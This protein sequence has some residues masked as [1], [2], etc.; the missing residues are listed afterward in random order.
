MN[1]PP[2]HPS[3]RGLPLA[4]ALSAA[5]ALSGP[6]LAQATPAA[7]PATTP[8][9]TQ[10]PAP[11]PIAAQNYTLEQA[12]AQLAGAPSVTRAALSVQVAQQNLEAARSALGLTVSVNGNASYVGSGAGTASDGAAT[13]T[14]A[15]LGGNAG[16]SVSLGLLPW[17]NNQS[18][19]RAS[20]RSLALARA[21][22]QEAQR[23]ARLNVTQAYFDAVLATQDLQMGAQTVALRTRQLQVAQAQDA[24]GNAAPEAVLSAQAALQAAQSA[25]AQA[26][27]TLDTA[28]RTLESALGV[29]LGRVTFSPPAQATL[30][31]P[32]V[33][34]LVARARTGRADVISAQNT[35]AA[36]QDTLDTAVRDATLP[37]LTA[38]VGYGG[39][40]AGTLST[41][42]NLKQGTLSSAYSVPVGSS[43]GSAS[44]RLTASLSGSY[45]VYSPAQRAS[46][47]ADQASVTQAALSLTVAQQNVELDVR[48]RFITAQQALTAVQ[49][50]QTQVQV[51]QQQLATAQARVQAGTA[52]PD[53]VQ[54]AELTLAQAQRD[55]LSARLS[56]QTTLI[57]LDNAAGGPQ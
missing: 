47:S 34:A 6:A 30:T 49:T 11:Q 29:S 10:A 19:L 33:A 43:S 53:D 27:G 41:S 12:Y 51:A 20:E 46:L 36:A 25:A 35:L 17:S 57:Q 4:L 22:L 42:L 14:A 40:S 9:T 54:S 52:T 37:D 38:S 7:P 45:V 1:L 18:S 32:D 48:S 5:L 16:V 8:T 56:A 15:S 28:Q 21:T 44:G 2:A 26:Q 50:R 3:R 13:T 39:G 23:S 24:A 31:L 55:L